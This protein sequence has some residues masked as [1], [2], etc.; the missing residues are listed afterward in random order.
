MAS[1][2]TDANGYSTNSL[3]T[4]RLRWSSNKIV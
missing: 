3:G 4:Q 1:I 2:S